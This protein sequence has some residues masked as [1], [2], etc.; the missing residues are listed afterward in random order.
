MSNCRSFGSDGAILPEVSFGRHLL[1]NDSFKTCK[2]HQRRIDHAFTPRHCQY[3]SRRQL[4][5]VATRS[6][7]QTAAIADNSVHT[8]MP[9]TVP[10]DVA[11]ALQFGEPPPSGPSA[12][13]RAAW[14][15]LEFFYKTAWDTPRR[16]RTGP[17]HGMGS[18]IH[19]SVWPLGCLTTTGAAWR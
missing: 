13:E 17:R 2:S 9:A 11:K 16:R 6:D 18:K 14:D 15:P 5:V 10:V 19:R 12:D 3:D 7:A 4:L 8:N 1:Q